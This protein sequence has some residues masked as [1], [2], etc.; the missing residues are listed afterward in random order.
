MI[1]KSD[2]QPIKTSKK[3]LLTFIVL[4][5]LIINDAKRQ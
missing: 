3:Q 1:F 5:L 4:I 2:F